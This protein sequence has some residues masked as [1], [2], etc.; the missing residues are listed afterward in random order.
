[1]ATSTVLHSNHYGESILYDGC[2]TCDELSKNIYILSDDELQA[3]ARL[4]ISES[5]RGLS[6][7]ESR[8]ISHLRIYHHTV[9]RAE[10]GPTRTPARTSRTDTHQ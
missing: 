10:Y 5:T 3:L 2:D 1:M 9:E 7:N 6:L 4:A 8:A